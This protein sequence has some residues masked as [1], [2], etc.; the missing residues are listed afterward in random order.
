MDVTNKPQRRLGVALQDNES[1]PCWQVSHSCGVPGSKAGTPVL[2]SQVFGRQTGSIAALRVFDM[3]PHY[4]TYPRVGRS[5]GQGPWEVRTTPVV[6]ARFQS[7]P[8]KK[9]GWIRE[10][11]LPYGRGSVNE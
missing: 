4:R 10:T 7:A 3:P 9:R 6:G 8:I 5:Y 1:A 11:P 2:A